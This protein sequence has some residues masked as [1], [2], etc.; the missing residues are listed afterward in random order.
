[1]ASRNDVTGDEI[2]SKTS[3]K[4]YADNWDRIFGKKD[5]EQKP[6]NKNAK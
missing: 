1:M 6:V 2:K 5:K 3:N 4:Q